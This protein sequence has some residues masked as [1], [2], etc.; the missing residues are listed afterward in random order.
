M[1]WIGPYIVPLV[2]AALVLRRMIKTQKA[3]PVR[4]W[5]LWLMPAIMVLVALG[6]LFSSFP[7]IV[8]L[9]FFIL[10]AGAG[11]A[12]GWF[13]VHTLE[14]STDPETGAV[15]TKGTPLSAVLFVGLFAARW[16]LKDLFHN[17]GL[18]AATSFVHWTDAGLMF[19]ASLL[20]AQS[21]H[22]WVRARA[23]LPPPVTQAV[24]PAEQK[25]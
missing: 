10:A 1:S 24:I 8:A 5:R 2:L 14:F 13:R 3:R 25:E 22:T 15:H 18:A 21:A 11:G 12:L 19:T 16:G 17:T 7:G 4:F 20:A 23:L 6:T 9:L